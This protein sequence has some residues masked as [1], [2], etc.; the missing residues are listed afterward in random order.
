MSDDNTFL[1]PVGRLV[2]GDCF[3]P[4][5]TDTE[6]KPL[7]NTA[8]ELTKKWFLGVAF[9]KSDPGLPTIFGKM[10]A[11]ALQGF[12]HN[13]HAKNGVSADSS[14]FSWKLIDGDGLDGNG[15]SYTE[16]EGFAGCW[17]LKF[18][19]GYPPKCFYA[20]RYQPHEQIQDSNA[21]RRGYFVRVAGS[22]TPNNSA[23]RPGVYVNLSMVELVAIGE[24]IQSGPNA[25]DV[26]GGAPVPANLPPGATALPA[27][28][29]AAAPA[30]PAAAPAGPAAAPASPAGPAAAPASP[31]G[32]A[33][34]AGVQ[35]A[36][37]FLT[38]AAP[39]APPAAPA[40][41]MTAAA[42]GVTYDAYVKA[43]WTDAQMIAAG[44]L[45]A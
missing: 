27:G 36:P 45:V 39:P 9:P 30:G 31:A 16:R 14:V 32:P 18:A 4:Q 40:K 6:G 21:I 41:Q 37:D 43:G 19:S 5:E 7:R 42:G 10:N 35:P 44:L 33:A 34:P 26:F 15:K 12:P 17:V 29:P 8:G 20:G 3:T 11:A 25:S 23:K 38:P 22:I 13:A 2:M 1:T 24:E 28:G